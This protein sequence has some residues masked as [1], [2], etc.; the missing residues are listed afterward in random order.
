MCRVTWGLLIDQEECSEDFLE[1]LGM[2]PEP[3]S[4]DVDSERRGPA[5]PR[6]RI[7]GWGGQVSPYSS[8]SKQPYSDDYH[9]SKAR[10]RQV[11]SGAESKIGIS[12]VFFNKHVL[13]VYSP[14]ITIFIIMFPWIIPFYLL[15]NLA[16]PVEKEF[17]FSCYG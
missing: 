11:R 9:R 4:L 14:V 15:K 17:S 16:K 1:E 2:C 10:M 6:R 5:E 13:H 3:N 12:S 7:W 8:P